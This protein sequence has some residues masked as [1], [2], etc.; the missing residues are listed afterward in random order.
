V[1]RLWLAL[2]AAYAVATLV[3]VGFV[4]AHEP[5]SFD[6]WNVAWDTDAEPFSLGRL[7]RY[8]G[9]EYTHSNPRIG[10][11]VAY[12][13]YKLS[14]FAEVATPLAYL[15]LSLAVTVLAIGRWPWRKAADLALWAGA[16]GGC[17]LLPE[18]GR[19]M[20][21]RAYATNYVYTAALQLWFVATLRLVKQDCSTRT[22][23]LYGALGLVAGM[24]NEHTGPAL[25]AL[26]GGYGWWLRRQEQPARLAWAGVVGFALGFLVIFF[27]PGQGER[28]DA[29]ATKTSLATRLLQ[30]GVITNLGIVGDYLRYA[31]PLLAVIVIALL[32]HADEANRR[33]ALRGIGIALAFG[34]V[35]AATLFVSPRL[36]SRFFIVPC[37]LLLAGAL[38]MID[39]I[40][41]RVPLLVLAVAASIYAA[42]RTVPLYARAAREST[43]RLALLEGAPPGATVWADA[44]PQVEESWWF[45]GDDFRTAHQRTAVARYLGL[46]RIGFR[47]WDPDAPLGAS[48]VQILS[49]DPL[50]LAGI[51]PMD[52]AA[53]EAAIRDQVSAGEVTVVADG[54]VLPRGKLLLARWRDGRFEAYAGAIGRPGVSI[55]R[56]VTLPPELA[57]KELYVVQIGS[58]TRPL[59]ASRRYTPWRTGVYWVLACDA[60]ECWLV[61][62]GRNHAA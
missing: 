18:L 13:A 37:A 11:P 40:P 1:R 31:A 21:S 57:G 22:A 28:Y 39:T 16:L 15:A 3:H 62:A 52:L 38:A 45:I 32:A 44:F 48:G 47:G 9:H 46:Q 5:F 26:V 41:Q 12:C 29:L 55:E 19:N 35:V 30:R 42:A 61:A 43:A 27:A 20:F 53:I 8:W 34:A 36:G 56:E 59:P 24:C 54:V 14:G 10:Q 25:V 2:F 33:R 50:D 60:S 23:I 58:E 17:W 7:V 51:K 6:A 49:A 4:V